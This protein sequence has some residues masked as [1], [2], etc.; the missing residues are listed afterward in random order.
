MLFEFH[1]QTSCQLI[2]Y[3]LAIEAFVGVAVA[4]F[5]SAILFTKMQRIEN[6]A[7]IEFSSCLC[8]QYGQGVTDTKMDVIHSIGELN[9]LPSSEVTSFPIIEMRLVN[10]VSDSWYRTGTFPYCIWLTLSCLFNGDIREAITQK[11][12]LSMRRSNVL[13]RLF[14][15]QTRAKHQSAYATRL[16]IM[17]DR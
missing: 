2:R 1:N 11:E 3:T 14:D 7:N 12:R 6:S 10:A 4:S 5:C 9:S 13:P 16:I 17:K 15:C 8:L